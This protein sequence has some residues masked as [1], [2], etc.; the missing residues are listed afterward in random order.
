M[1]KGILN[2]KFMKQILM[3]LVLLHN[4]EHLLV[5]IGKKLT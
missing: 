2:H 5:G 1:I 3:A 4:S